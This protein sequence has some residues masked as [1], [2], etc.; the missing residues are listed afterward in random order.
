M[1]P[2]L[3]FP[4]LV[5]VESCHLSESSC[6]KPAWGR[7]PEIALQFLCAAAASVLILLSGEAGA[8]GTPDQRTAFTRAWQ[9]A[10]NG[11][12]R[13]FGE[14]MPG[15][16]G[17]LLYPYLQY[18][19][20][21]HRRSQADTVEMSAFING[22]RDWAF[23]P[24]LETTWLRALGKRKKWDDLLAHAG[25]SADTE[26][27]CYL[28]QARIERG[29]TQDLLDEA[30]KLWTVGRSQ[31]KAC[32]PVFRWLQQHDGITS[33][34]AWQRIRL[35]M[36][37]RQTGLARYLA[38]FLD[39]DQRP[40]SDRWLQ[41]D[42]GAYRRLDR[43]ARW[44]DTPESRSITEYGLRRLARNDPDRAW[45]VFGKLD[46]HF[47]W[48]EAIRQGILGEI[49]IW[50]AVNGL[51]GTPGRM[52]AV[53]ARWRDD[54]LL[55]WWA[56][57]ALS[58]GDWNALL[59]VAGGFSP[60]LAND[61]RWRFWMARAQ[62]E[63]G[64]ATAARSTYSA[65]AQ[66]AS[67]YGFLAADA[68]EL[69][70]TICAQEPEIGSGE[71]DRLSHGPGFERALELRRA[72]VLNWARSEWTLAAQALDRQGLRAAAAL[73]Q[74]ENWPDMAIFALGNSGDW[75]WYEWRF[76]VDYGP[77]VEAIAADSSLD[78]SWVLGLMR[79]ESA[80]A[81]DAVSSAGAR[82]LM[83]VTPQTARQVAHRHSFHYRGRHQLLQP[84]DNVR[85]GTAYLRDLMERYGGSQVLA[86]GAYNA[87]PK[88]VDRWLRER[89]AGDPAAWIDSLPYFETR[90]YI[91]R[92][93]AFSAIYD[94]RRGKPVQRISS[95]MLPFD[96]PASGGTMQADETAKVVCKAPG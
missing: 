63:A 49:A 39:S 68:L 40:W 33:G 42:R 45:K 46:G 82:G 25:D 88:V 47:G 12:R 38:R 51:D 74:R 59:A 36:Q 5:L 75:R 65:L 58:I 29:R 16:R 61:A 44:P 43:A 21:R 77:M 81:T 41:Q 28:A 66:E 84:E 85:F 6:P 91:P 31:P 50:S 9:A 72:G 64:N 73:A 79:S 23:R 95:R 54:R 80:M 24:G 30:R 35:A 15:L 52:Q 90:D 60:E 56:R 22:H 32:D 89:P 11:D 94:W 96:S 53:D 67:Y 3:Q 2:G 70:Y 87:G 18:E 48:P 76:P 69:P 37:A 14:L 86:S 78:P 55:E 34:L 1:P 4:I 8:S 17:Y 26:V 20:L 57:Y 13:T 27:R 93:L 71:V 10:A 92:V 7:I 83:Q 62:Q 19:D